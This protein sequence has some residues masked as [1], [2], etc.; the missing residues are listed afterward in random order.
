MGGAVLVLLVVVLLVLVLRSRR[1]NQ[2][3]HKPISNASYQS[4]VEVIN[5]LADDFVQDPSTLVPVK[6]M[7]RRNSKGQLT[8]TTPEFWVC[9]CPCRRVTQ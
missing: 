6:T 8:A 9:A 2:P 1:R 7:S 3:L 5:P 4:A